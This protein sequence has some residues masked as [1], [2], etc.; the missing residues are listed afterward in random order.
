MVDRILRWHP[1]FPFL[2][3]IH[4]LPGIQS[5]TNLGTAI[6]HL[7][8]VF[9]VLS[10]LSLKKE[11]ILSKPGLIRWS[12]NETILPSK[13]YLKQEK[14]STQGRLAIAVLEDKRPTFFKKCDKPLWAELCY[15]LPSSKESIPQATM[16]RNWILSQPHVPERGKLS[17]HDST[18]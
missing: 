10:K 12:L 18:A 13:R 7:A 15:Q 1:R 8:D 6:K 5:N 2:V 14:Y 11:I 4:I 9:N 16:S 3:G 17:S